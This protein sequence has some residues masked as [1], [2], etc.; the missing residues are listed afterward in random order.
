MV[1]LAVRVAPEWSICRGDERV[2]RRSGS[3]SICLV[4]CGL[5]GTWCWR[6]SWPGGPRPL[7]AII[8]CCGNRRGTKDRHAA[9]KDRLADRHAGRP[10]KHYRLFKDKHE[11]F[12][13]SMS[14]DDLGF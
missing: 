11:R 13:R 9:G 8:R 12:P 6:A 3:G 7:A 5:L 10:A 14:G 4:S 2:S 1:V